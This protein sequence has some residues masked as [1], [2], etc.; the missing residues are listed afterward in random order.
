MKVLAGSEPPA[1]AREAFMQ[2]AE[3]AKILIEAQPGEIV[4]LG[5]GR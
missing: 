2:A 1:V 4:A 3:E 5:N